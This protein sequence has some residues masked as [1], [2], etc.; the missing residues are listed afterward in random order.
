MKNKIVSILLSLAIAIGLWVYVI[1]VVDPEYTRTYKVPVDPAQFQYYSVLEERNL[2][3]MECDEYV[4]LRLKGNRSTL[5]AIRAEDLT[6][7][8]SLANV[9]KAGEY[10]LDYTVNIPGAVLVEDPQPE[11]I[12]LRVDD[13]ITR[14]LP[15]KADI[16]GELP[17]NFAADTTDIFPDD[18]NDTITVVG[19]H[20]VMKNIAFAKLD[21]T[22]DLTGK[23]EDVIGEY[24]LVLCDIHGNPVDA[25]G[26][27]IIGSKKVAVRIRIEMYKD[28]K[29]T[30][31]ITEG[32]GLTKED[33]TW[34]HNTIRI[35]GPKTAIEALGDT[36]VLGELDLASL[37]MTV[38]MAPFVID[39]KDDR[40]VNRS[41]VTEVT[42]TVD[43][44]DMRQKII[45]IPT[46]Q[47]L[48]PT[49][50]DVEV[51][52]KVLKVILRGS[53]E[54]LEKITAS[55]LSAVVDYREAAA[56]TGIVV[57]P[58]ITVTNSKFGDVY[59][60]SVGDV[61]ATVK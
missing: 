19:P 24:E 51:D 5:A 8:A 55:D 29:L 16:V 25:E 41:G 34:D 40:L 14:E 53:A 7:Q 10:Y 33:V 17:A 18:D 38:P 52:A 27:T 45:E 9:N 61:T 42:V 57:K 28:I 43:F 22:I 15:I 35:S 48:K 46:F 39:L 12:F 21:G 44:G 36:L 3:V 2:Q 13:E 47:V 26:V 50:L 4:T 20:S 56:G 60:V 59:V 58:E 37:D 49:D 54:D 6:I 11:K 23:E 1:T 30:F 31:D 32:G